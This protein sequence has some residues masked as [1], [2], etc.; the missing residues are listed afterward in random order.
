MA[1]SRP[2]QSPPGVRTRAYRPAADGEWIQ[3]VKRGYKMRC[4]DCG[5]VHVLNFRLV[6]WR[7]QFQAF[8]D[9]RKTAASRRERAKATEAKEEEDGLL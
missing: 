4:C 1:N 8:R 5:L 6:G 2:G 3:P 9:D 7:I